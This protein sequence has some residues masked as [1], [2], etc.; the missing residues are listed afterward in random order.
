MTPQ[1][2]ALRRGAPD[3]LL[4]FASSGEDGGNAIKSLTEL[5]WKIKVT[6]N[7][8]IG[9][10]API[11]EQ[12]AGKEALETV[13]GSNYR[14]FTYC[15]GGD[16]PKPYLDLVAKAKAADPKRANARR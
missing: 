4:L 10:F 6:G 13:T 9:A 8:T 3:T 1:L 15:E 2:L 5:G 16:K 14:G 7:W 11:V 12:I